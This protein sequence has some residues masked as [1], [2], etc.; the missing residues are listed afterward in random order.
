MISV[1]LHFHSFFHVSSPIRD[2]RTSFCVQLFQ[3]IR[4]GYAACFSQHS[5]VL[6]S[7]YFCVANDRATFATFACHLMIVF[8]PDEIDCVS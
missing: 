8:F 3:F 7:A 4:N 1:T 5:F 6:C 2:F